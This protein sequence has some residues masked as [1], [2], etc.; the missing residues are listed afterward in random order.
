M[1]SIAK[2]SLAWLLALVPA[3]AIA[4]PAG[5]QNGTPS[6]V[7]AADGTATVVM[8]DGNRYTISGG[9]LS[10]DGSNLFHSFREFGLKPHEIATFLS[11]PNIRNILSRVTGGNASVIRGLIEVSG[12]TSNLFLIN[13]AGIIFGPEARLNVPGDFTAATATGIGFEDGGWF[14]AS[15]ANDY[16]N[17]VGDPNVFAFDAESGAIV[18]AGELSVADGHGLLLLGSS[19]ANTGTLSADDGRV[20]LA[21][22]EGT[23][24]VRVSLPGHLLSL[25]IEVQP[26]QIVTANHLPELLTGSGSDVATGLSAVGQTVAVDAT[27][28]LVP[29][30]PG[31]AIASGT[32]EAAEVQV[33]G[34]TVAVVGADIDASGNWGGGVVLIGGDTRGVG[35]LPTAERVFVDAGSTIAA[36]ALVNGE[37]GKV[38]IWADGVAGF[39]GEISARGAGAGNAGGFVEVSG[40]E[41]L[42][43]DGRIDASAPAGS[44]GTILLDPRN[45]F[46]VAEADAPDNGELSDNQILFA[47]GGPT[48]DFTISDVALTSLMGNVVLEAQN[49]ISAE[50]AAVLDLGQITG[51]SISF[52]AGNDIILNTDIST[53]GGDVVLTATNNITTQ[54]ISTGGGDVQIVAAS[55]NITTQ[56][57]ETT[58]LLPG[59]SGAVDLLAGGAIATGSIATSSSGGTGGAITV[60]SGTGNIDT[61]SLNASGGEGSGG[62]V[63]LLSLGG[64]GNILTGSIDASGGSG[65]GTVVIY[66]LGGFVRVTDTLPN[67]D[68]NGDPVSIS[69]SSS[70]GNSGAITIFHGGNGEIPF[71]VGDSELNGSEGVP[72]SGDFTIAP[73]SYLFTEVQG[74]QEGPGAVAISPAP[75]IPDPDIPDPDIPEPD[76]PEPEDPDI[77]DPDIEDPETPLLPANTEANPVRQEQRPVTQNLAFR[78]DLDDDILTIQNAREILQEIERATGIKSALLY[79]NF[80]PAAIA[81]ET[82]SRA[83]A[84]PTNG[85]VAAAPALPTDKAYGSIGAPPDDLTTSPELSVQ[86]ADGAASALAGDFQRI[87]AQF[88]NEFEDFLS[89]PEEKASPTLTT[90]YRDGD[91]LEILLVTADSPPKRLVVPEATRAEVLELAQT[92]YGFVSDPRFI[93]T[94]DYLEPSQQLYNW[95]L[96]PLVSDLV[97]N[98]IDNL[99]FVMPRGLRLLPVAALHD[100]EQF[101]AQRYSAGL[102]PSLSLNDN[103][104]RDVKDLRVYAVGASEFPGEQEQVPLPAVSVEVPAIASRLWRGD[105]VLN[106]DFTIEN[107]QAERRSN[108]TGIIHLATHADFRFD[109][110]NDIYIQFYDDRL[111]LDRIRELNLNDPPVELMVLS[112]CR[113]AVGNES[114]ELGFAGLAVQAGV[115][116]VV[117]SLWYVGD[118]GTLGLM[119]EF[120]NQ[121]NTAP[122]KAE[123]LQLAQVALIEGGVSKV[124][125]D[126]VG[127]SGTYALPEAAAAIEEDLSH[128]FYWAS[129]TAIGS[130]W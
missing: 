52:S 70:N 102:A 54:N 69:T 86:A 112:A 48:T 51:E 5:A 126:V 65:G 81:G 37:G 127:P 128:P 129:F 71:I 53:Q 40:R 122:I 93:G 95:L 28:Q 92:M 124:D 29:G 34:D 72:T 111:R 108:P 19:V 16:T 26:D 121:L 109:S 119:T 73:G 20:T 6:I 106:E 83:P 55:S 14:T 97:A 4:A 32:I 50:A 104:Y 15:G 10:G 116:T 125:G 101:V 89:L 68:P 117:A 36:D 58:S 2:K 56:N 45:I 11:N 22:V 3:L 67:S 47:D 41:A 98:E 8:P 33:F 1:N 30:G 12:G 107:F 39:S 76:I 100:G 43:V 25:E 74:N 80:A 23:N 88:T 7:E 118:T 62:N 57:I 82:A 77:E 123:A 90:P 61:L 63:F 110:P 35:P 59:D 21:A 27:G 9:T 66:T 130:P 91:R 113:T 42:F 96:A 78:P 44:D 17:L 114:Y 85:S 46:I 31:S 24:R 75:D 60:G 103:L 79:V 94:D 105:S 99:V 18:N 115:K 13:P 84:I 38:V 49:N 64:G 87:E 120:Y